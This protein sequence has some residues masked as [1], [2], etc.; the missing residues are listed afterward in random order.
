MQPHKPRKRFGQHFL[1]DHHIIDQIIQLID[2]HP[3]DQLIEI[4]PGLGAL[5]KAL[6]AILKHLSVIEL[7]RNLIAPLKRLAPQQQLTI[8]H[9]D[10]LT[11][12][13]AELYG[14][15][16]R[17]VGNLP[18]NISTP[19]IF[20]LL[21][22]I[23]HIHDMH[24]MFQKEVGLRLCAQP[25]DPH[26]GRLTVMTQ[27]YCQ[28]ELLLDVPPDSFKPPPQVDSV[29]VRL[30]PHNSLPFVAQN[31]SIF[32]DVVRQAFSQ[33]RKMLINSLKGYLK[34]ADFEIL[35]LSTQLRPEQLS[36]E[37]FVQISNFIDHPS[38]HR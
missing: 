30:K 2:P 15:K 13:L 14:S 23:H 26:Y 17:I 37:S 11:L 32:A 34:S 38:K 9:Q 29:F 27:Y 31:L 25:G 10:V 19:L 3:T 21:K 7:D 35:G 8:H 22:E 33:R 1:N 4:G 20:H 36:V 6:L 24:F 18:Y 5:T 12:C 28:N 16:C